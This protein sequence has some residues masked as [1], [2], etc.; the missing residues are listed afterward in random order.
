MRRTNIDYEIGKG[1]VAD[2]VA[3][4]DRIYKNRLEE[5]KLYENSLWDYVPEL[6][7]NFDYYNTLRFVR[8]W[9]I[10]KNELNVSDR[11]LIFC[12]LAC[13]SNYDECLSWFN[14]NGRDLKNVASLRVLICNVRKK[15]RTIYA[16][17][18]GNE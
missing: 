6:G 12:F 9:N 8:T 13:D 7:E 5:L 11:N 1:K 4:M 16:E 17:K 15:V 14:G 10:V 18:Y 2:Y 3:M